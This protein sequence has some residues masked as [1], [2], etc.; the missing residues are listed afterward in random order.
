[1]SGKHV[2][3]EEWFIIEKLGIYLERKWQFEYVQ[4]YLIL[5]V[6]K[7]RIIRVYVECKINNKN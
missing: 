2:V 6:I 4:S 5:A 1:M 7:I 3:L